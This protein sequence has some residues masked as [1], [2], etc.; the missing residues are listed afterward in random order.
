[1][2]GAPQMT[3]ASALYGP[4]YYASH[5]GPIPYDRSQEH[6]G[7]FFGGVADELI[8][9][10]QPARVF[11]AGCAHG[12]LVEA[13]WDRGVEARGCDISEFAISQVR[14]DIRQYCAATSLVEPIEGHY[15][16][17]VSIEVREHMPEA[18]AER[19]V[20]NIC[21]VTD[22]IVFSSSPTDFTEPTHINV[23]P[24]IYWL[25]LFAA[26]GFAPVTTLALA[27]ITPW[28]LAFE[29]RDTGREERDLI[30]C[31][32]LVWRRVQLNEANG[33]IGELASRL[34]ELSELQTRHN[35]LRAQHDELQA[36][37][38]DVL[39]SKAWRL[40][41]P[42]RSAHNLL[43]TSFSYSRRA[44]SQHLRQGRYAAR[45]RD[46]L[47]PVLPAVAD[48]ECSPRIVPPGLAA[49]CGP[50]PPD[51]SQ[52]HWRRFFSSS[53]DE[54]IR[55]FRPARVF[56]AGC[57]HGLLVE[58][59]WDRGVEARGRDVSEFA[60]SQVRADVR[61]YCSAVSLVE[62]IAGHYDLVVCIEALEHLPEVD[63]ERAI[64]NMCAVTDRI[65]FSS[66]PSGFNDPT[67]INLKPPVHW[68]RLFA[69]QGFAPVTTLG[70][71]SITPWTLAFERRGTGREERDL[72]ICAE[73]V[74][75]R[76]QLDQ[77]NRQIGEI[78]SRLNELS[79]LQTRITT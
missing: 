53:A 69:A 60:I 45:L 13:L 44:F 36:R 35:E 61:Q 22:R 3:A 2:T 17:V 54:L 47:K 23:K 27:C 15:D 21:A 74:W 7:R 25:R 76:S 72:I 56:D 68:L 78:S 9:V 37:H 24:P 16:L 52:E 71:A 20:A 18:E 43:L 50:I 48:R 79:D 5:C 65:V 38:L 64:A 14:A 59:L 42:I 77:A 33:K 63:A 73:L 19:A 40:S 66:S 57:A 75:R 62:P 46:K 29:R 11:D 8:R 55:V 26:Q 70:L 31:A 32:E 39:S 34:S 58:A 30:V 10:F 41:A 12:F 49:H 4:E 51:Q 1:M 6:W 28:A 67:D